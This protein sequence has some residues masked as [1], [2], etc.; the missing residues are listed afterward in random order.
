MIQLKPFLKIKR[1][2]VYPKLTPEEVAR[3][4][5]GPDRLFIGNKHQL[6][7]LIQEV[8]EQ[9]NDN[10]N[11]DEEASKEEND[12]KMEKEEKKEEEKEGIIDG[13]GN[14]NRLP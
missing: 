8:H 2:Q 10:N 7:S 11:H 14:S 12:V 6:F 4:S 9:G 5:I 1:I 3:N 13:K